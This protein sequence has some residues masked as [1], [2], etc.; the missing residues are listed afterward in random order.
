MFVQW[1]PEF[2]PAIFSGYQA[3]RLG[4]DP[5]SGRAACTISAGG[6]A[7]HGKK[8]A[9]FAADTLPPYDHE[10]Q[11]EREHQCRSTDPGGDRRRRW[12]TQVESTLTARKKHLQ[13]G[14]ATHGAY[15]N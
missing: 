2:G 1:K 4:G 5:D 3:P 8:P 14:R 12:R 13:R 10:L 9:Y 15:P 6:H 7:K 11:L